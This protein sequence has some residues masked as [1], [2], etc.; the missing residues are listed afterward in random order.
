MIQS[1]ALLTHL[2]LISVTWYSFNVQE[3]WTFFNLN[4]IIVF[5]S[6]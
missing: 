5:K 4:D 6:G 3:Q 2:Q 1:K